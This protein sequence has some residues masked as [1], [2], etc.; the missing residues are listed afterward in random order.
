MSFK[1]RITGK[2][3]LFKLLP[4]TLPSYIFVYI[5]QYCVCTC[6]S[7]LLNPT[8]SLTTSHKCSGKRSATGTTLLQTDDCPNTTTSCAA[9]NCCNKYNP[10]MS[11]SMTHEEGLTEKKQNFSYYSLTIKLFYVSTML[12]LFSCIVLVKSRYRIFKGVDLC[13]YF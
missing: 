11:L 4:L 9:S 8:T 10:I 3:V 1:Q 2:F 6:S 5:K 12:L 13:T 7:L